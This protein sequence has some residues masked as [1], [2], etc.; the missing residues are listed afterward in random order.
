M[1][2]TNGNTPSDKPGEKTLT[3]DRERIMRMDFNALAEAEKVSGK[4]FLDAET[5]R[6]L[7]ATDMRAIAWA[8]LHV[9]D[10]SLTL[11]QVGHMMLMSSAEISD[12]VFELY[13][14]QGAAPIDDKKE[15]EAPE[16]S[17][18]SVG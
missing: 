12:A 1:S 16:P 10:P 3:L 6:S 11:D 7:S 5:W 18:T 17:L 2:G 14:G 15:A 13:M 9:Y 4:N 8:C